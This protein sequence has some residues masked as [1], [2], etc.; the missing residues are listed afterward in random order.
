MVQ[1]TIPKVG[2]GNDVYEFDQAD[3]LG[4]K[5]AQAAAAEGSRPTEQRFP[6]RVFGVINQALEYIAG[7]ISQ[8]L[9]AATNAATSATA[10]AAARAGAETAR[11]AT[12]AA[13]AG[14]GV[15]DGDKGDIIVSSA[16][17]SWVIDNNA[18]SASKIANNALTTGKIADGAVTGAKIEAGATV[19]IKAASISFTGT[20]KTLVLTDANTYQ[21]CDNASA[22]TVAIPLNNSVAI[23]V[24]SWITFEQHGA[25]Q[26][27]LDADS[28]VSLNGIDG[29]S[30]KVAERWNAIMLRKIGTNSWI[31]YGALE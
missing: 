2:G 23:P 16:G 28:G 22:Q 21:Q 17:T 3:Y 6:N 31:G 24:G 5:H 20:S 13:A 11:D 14:A 1:V 29:G 4:M 8:A 25:G 10:A 12:I 27:T 15:T 30:I 18:V 26:V 7:A 19:N 9:I